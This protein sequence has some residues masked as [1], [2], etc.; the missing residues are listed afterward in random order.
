MA[1]ESAERF[2]EW[3]LRVDG[4]DVR[5]ELG[6]PMFVKLRARLEG[7]HVREQVFVGD[8]EG[9][10]ALAGTL[11]MLGA[12]WRVFRALIRAGRPFHPEGG[13]IVQF[14]GEQE[15]RRALGYEGGPHPL[16]DGL[17]A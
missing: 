9:S 17:G 12:E 13:V 2:E 4:H 3:D 14:E 10:L 5:D 7:G 8:R 1:Q 15:T 11:T 6:T 16:A